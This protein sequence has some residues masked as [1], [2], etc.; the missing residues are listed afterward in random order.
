[1]GKL[2]ASSANA[3]PPKAAIP[4]A[5]TAIADL[6]ADMCCAP[7]LLS[8]LRFVAYYSS[9]GAASSR[10]QVGASFFAGKPATLHPVHSNFLLP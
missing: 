10:L 6:R 7:Y 4:K 9:S 8:S 3:A 1:M 5:I 2:F